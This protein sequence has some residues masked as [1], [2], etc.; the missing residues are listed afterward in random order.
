[1]TDMSWLFFNVIIIITVVVLVVISSKTLGVGRGL[2]RPAAPPSAWSLKCLPPFRWIICHFYDQLH[3]TEI[4]F[5]SAFVPAFP[6][7]TAT[8]FTS[9]ISSFWMTNDTWLWFNAERQLKKQ[10]QI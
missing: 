5:F 8:F 1:M 6:L 10:N 4:R 3:P 7:P 9:A 2:K